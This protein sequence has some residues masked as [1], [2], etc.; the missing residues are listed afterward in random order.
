MILSRIVTVLRQDGRGDHC[1]GFSLVG[2]PRH[3]A[4]HLLEQPLTLLIY[5]SRVFGILMSCGEGR[6][7]ETRLVIYTKSLTNLSDITLLA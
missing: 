4:D 2:A 1:L 6:S 3:A 7:G 5:R